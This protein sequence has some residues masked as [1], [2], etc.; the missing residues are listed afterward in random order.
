VDNLKE[1]VKKPWFWIAVAVVA[2]FALLSQRRRAGASAAPSEAPS[3]FLGAPGAGGGAPVTGGPSII[4]QLN[5]L[6]LDAAKQRLANEQIQFDFS[7]R[8]EERRAGILA[9][10]EALQGAL[11]GIQL[12]TDIEQA[13]RLQQAGRKAKVECPVGMHLVNT[14]EEGLHCQPKGGGGFKPF[15]QIGDIFGG[16]LGGVAAA[17]PGI[18]YGAANAYAG[19]QGLFTPRAAGSTSRQSALPTRTRESGFTVYAA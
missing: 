11:Q 12:N 9:P 16:L 5:Q 4:D 3:S 8:E 7:Q 13:G 17:A 18:G 6:D 10:L 19:R 15:K 1:L 14:P 2:G